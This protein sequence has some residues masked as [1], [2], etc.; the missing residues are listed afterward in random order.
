MIELR[1]ARVDDASE[2]ARIQVAATRSQA[3]DYYS[4]EQIEQLAPS[5]HGSENIDHAVFDDDDYYTIIAEDDDEIVGFSIVHLDERYLSGIFIDPNYTGNGIG[6][7]LI[8]NVEKRSRRENIQSLETYAALNAV[9]FYESCGFEIKE[10]INTNEAESPD[11][12][13]IRMKKKI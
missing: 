3:G 2:M 12:P 9:G 8:E 6:K 13:A 11:I 7:N 10:E 5:D 1:R 4:E